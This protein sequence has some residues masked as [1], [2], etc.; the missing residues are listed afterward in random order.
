MAVFLRLKLLALLC[1]GP[2]QSISLADLFP[3]LHIHSCWCG[4]YFRLMFTRFT[5]LVSV[6]ESLC[7]GS[8]NVRQ[9]PRLF[10]AVLGLPHCAKKRAVRAGRL[11]EKNDKCYFTLR[12][13]ALG[14]RAPHALQSATHLRHACAATA[15]VHRGFF[16]VSFLFP[17]LFSLFLY[18][19]KNAVLVAASD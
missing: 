19:Y 2:R 3:T 11:K 5:A 16:F 6:E 1:L 17:F 14:S 15:E 4:A 7:T 9:N 18:L 12:S 13:L 8:R 10:Y